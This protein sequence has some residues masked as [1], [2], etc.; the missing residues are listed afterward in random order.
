MPLLGLAPDEVYPAGRSPDL[1]WALTPPFHP[2]RHGAGGVVSVALSA[3]HPAW[4]LPSVLPCGARTFLGWTKPPAAARPAHILLYHVYPNKT[5]ERGAPAARMRYNRVMKQI[6]LVQK[7]NFPRRLP[8]LGRRRGHLVGHDGAR[9]THRPG[10]QWVAPNHNHP[11]ETRRAQPHPGSVAGPSDGPALAIRARTVC[12][13][14]TTA[15]PF[16]P[17]ESAS[18]E[19][20]SVLEPSS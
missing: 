19:R 5:N 11:P 17:G 16:R 1:W 13:Y 15:H 18:G 2:Y 10:R 3:G 7:S 12:E 8:D 20:C 6:G 4:V 14:S 9:T